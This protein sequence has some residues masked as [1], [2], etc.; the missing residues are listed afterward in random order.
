MINYLKKIPPFF[1]ICLFL[2]FFASCQ[3]NITTAW[4]D[5]KT[6][7]RYIQRQGKLLWN[8]D[9]DSKLIENE[10]DFI[11]PQEEEYIPLSTNEKTS[12]QKSQV[13]QQ[14]REIPGEQN[15]SIPSIESFSKPSNQLASIFKTMYFDT[16]YHSL[17]NKS[18]FQQVAKIA[19]CMKKD[20]KLYVFIS[21]H[22]DERASE[23]YNLALGTRRANTIRGLLIKRGVNPENIYTIS[24]GKEMPVDLEHN[25]QAWEKNRRIEFKIYEKRNEK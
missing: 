1:Y 23:G 15:S 19:E 11:Q 6:M 22:C 25:A 24:Y 18:D 2:P 14:P 9:I 13:S 12:T 7:G 10:N 8:S 17:K 20:P 3:R 5:T 21:G 4:E 16:D